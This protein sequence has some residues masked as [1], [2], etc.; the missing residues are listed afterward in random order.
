MTEHAKKH[1]WLRWALLAL[2]IALGAL[3]FDRARRGRY[4]FHHFYLD[5]RYVWEHGALNDDF[6][7]ADPDARRQ[8]PFY[9]PTVSLLLAPLTAFGRT[10]A[11]L[12]WTVGQMLALLYS[13]T[14]LRRWCAPERAGPIIITLAFAI[15]A[16]IEAA[17]FNQVS[18]FVLALVLTGL[19]AL[20]H[21]HP[22]RGGA[23]L[24]AAAVL[25]LLPAIFLPWLLLKRQWTA[26]V[27]GVVAGAL[28]TIIPPT[29][30]FGPKNA[31]TY[32]HEWWQHNVR[33]EAAGGMLN[34]ELPEHFIDRRNQSITQ[35]LA[36]WTWPQHPYQVPWQPFEL[37]AATC[38]HTAQGFGLLLGVVFLAALHRPWNRLTVDQ[39]HAEA[40]AVAVGMLVFSPLLRQYYLVWVLPALILFATSATTHQRMRLRMTGRIGLAVWT[41]GMI[42]W[43]WPITRVMGAHLVMLIA[44]GVLLLRLAYRK[45]E[46]PLDTHE[47][48]RDAPT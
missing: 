6:D 17:R 7:N 36:R 46:S 40:A 48:T 2:L 44:L 43:I 13:I 41:I 39:R 47:T 15:P 27:A 20:D 18:Y 33:G 38:R 22:W 26:A 19:D 25:K 21:K 8:L 28:L 31:A 4:D 10:P 14:V 11:A 16:F 23:L 35:V 9:L 32:H 42:A 45:T 30:V 37:S 5:A 24:G 29:L 12:V 34:P 1:W 3:S